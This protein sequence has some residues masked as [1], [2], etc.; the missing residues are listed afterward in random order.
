MQKQRRSVAFS[1][2][3]TS[4]S[5]VWELAIFFQSSFNLLRYFFVSHLLSLFVLDSKKQILIPKMNYFDLAVITFHFFLLAYYY[6]NLNFYPDFMHSWSHPLLL[7]SFIPD[8]RQAD[9]L[10]DFWALFP[11]LWHWIFLSILNFEMIFAWEF[12]SLSDNL[13]YIPAW[14][15]PSTRLTSIIWNE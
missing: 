4:F 10:N 8:L 3:G 7:S 2:L 5:I 1:T 13:E 6:F 15:F 11:I 12:P 14:F 9:F